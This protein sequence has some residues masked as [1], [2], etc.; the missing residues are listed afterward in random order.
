MAVSASRV[1]EIA[2]SYEGASE[3]PHF[4][5][6]ALRTPRKS[7]ATLACDGLDI[8]LAFDLDLQAHYCRMDPVAFA[9]VAGGW[10]RMGFTR[11]DLAKVDEATLSS[12]LHAAYVQALPR[13]QR[14]TSALRGRPTAT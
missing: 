4:D 13:P 3:R 9:P 5:R 10:G 11:C 8:N 1:R 12:A 7:F 6:I 14:K 2:L